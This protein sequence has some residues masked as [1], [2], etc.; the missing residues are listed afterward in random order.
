MKSAQDPLLPASIPA[1]FSGFTAASI[2]TIRDF[3]ARKT[4]EQSLAF[5]QGL[6]EV[7]GHDGDG[8]RG[9]IAEALNSVGI[10]RSDAEQIAIEGAALMAL[11]EDRDRKAELFEAAS[12]AAAAKERS[13]YER[14]G[15]FA[16]L[17]R[18]KLGPGS[19]ALACF[20]VPPEPGLAPPS[21]RS[22]MRPPPLE[23]SASF[24]K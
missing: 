23:A 22:S 7:L 8:D 11:L 19:P 5:A 20:G 16:R 14:L 15:S 9:E 2:A 12:R 13:L 24:A 6:A 10:Y 17:L 1:P 4:L 21:R 18:L 3:T